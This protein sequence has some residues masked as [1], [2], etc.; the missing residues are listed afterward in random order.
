MADPTWYLPVCDIVLAKVQRWLTHYER[1]DESASRKYVT[2]NARLI[3][4]PTKYAHRMKFKPIEIDHLIRLMDALCEH[5]ELVEDFRKV[6][7][8]MQRGRLHPGGYYEVVLNFYKQDV[9]E[10]LEA[11]IRAKTGKL[12]TLEQVTKENTESGKGMFEV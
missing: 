12:K 1:G 6:R 11:L 8:G 4:M 5:K 9:A 2:M 10:I 3:D 7:A